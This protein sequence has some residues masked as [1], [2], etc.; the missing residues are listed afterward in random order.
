MADG[1]GPGAEKTGNE[2]TGSANVGKVILH[3]AVATAFVLVCTLFIWEQGKSAGMDEQRAAQGMSGADVIQTLFD[4]VSCTREDCD[5]RFE[6][7][8]PGLVRLTVTE[9]DGT[10]RAFI[11]NQDNGHVHEA[12]TILS[13]SN[14]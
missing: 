9:P 12:G 13:M 11:W 4:H 3:M 2:E 7:V 1:N 5:A 8:R 14:P 10:S 6:R